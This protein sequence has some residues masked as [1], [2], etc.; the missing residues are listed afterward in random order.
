MSVAN[1]N[2]YPGDVMKKATGEV[3]V[4]LGYYTGKP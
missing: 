2:M 4:Y 1:K 3:Y